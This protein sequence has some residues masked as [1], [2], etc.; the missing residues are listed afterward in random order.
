[1]WFL[2]TF[3]QRRTQQEQGVE[4]LF[5]YSSWVVRQ[6]RRRVDAIDAPNS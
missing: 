2:G 6:E 1:M 4:I 3:A 5:G